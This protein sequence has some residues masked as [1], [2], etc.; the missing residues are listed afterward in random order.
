MLFNTFV[1][2][3][4]NFTIGQSDGGGTLAPID[5]TNANNIVRSSTGPL[6]NILTQPANFCGR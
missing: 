2:C 4:N 5:C 1:G 6:V 3:S